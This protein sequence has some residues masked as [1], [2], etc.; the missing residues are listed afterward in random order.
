MVGS[1]PTNVYSLSKK[2]GRIDTM[3]L[4][5][6]GFLAGFV[7]FPLAVFFYVVAVK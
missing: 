5:V 6:I 3:T 1:A 2:R 4:F 7:T